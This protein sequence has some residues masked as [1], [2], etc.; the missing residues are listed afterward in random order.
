MGVWFL[1]D[2]STTIVWAIAIV[3]WYP[4]LVCIA[5]SLQTGET[6]VAASAMVTMAGVS[7][8]MATIHGSASQ[9]PAM[10]RVTPMTRLQAVLWTLGQTI[11][12][13]GIFLWVLPMGI[14]ELEQIGG[15]STFNHQRQTPLSIGMFISS[16][17]FGLWSGITIA[18]RG[19]GTPLPTATAPRLVISGPY[20]FVRNPMALAGILQGIAVGWY[21][22]SAAVVGYSLV[23]A[24]FWHLIVRP[25]EE[26]ELL[27]RFGN[28]YECYR[29]TV[30]LWIPSM[31]SV[32]CDVDE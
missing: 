17:C 20:R 14:A 21:M 27:D 25:I 11:I 16:S 22:G 5:T 12:F 24:F 2:W 28:R 7:V 6:W 30:G 9:S 8:M 13:W 4:T 32:G 1:R 10:I 29:E 26:R 18:T 3:T 23:G 15:L 19:D 31:P